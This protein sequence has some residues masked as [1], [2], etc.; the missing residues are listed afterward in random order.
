MVAVAVGMRKKKT[1]SALKKDLD[2]VFNAWI[3]KRDTNEGGTFT[4]ISSG[5]T[6]PANEM[7]AGHFYPA[8]YTAIRWDERNVNGQS[9]KDNRFKCG[10]LLGYYKGMQAKWGQDV[11]DE[12]E[13]LHNQP[14]KLE[15]FWLEEMIS[16]Y[17]E[18]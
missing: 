5:R 6:L 10:N 7:D 12:L 13:R 15:I 4:C 18:R 2:K 14:F 1:L 9:R 11:I 8:T 16:K 17:K 3:R